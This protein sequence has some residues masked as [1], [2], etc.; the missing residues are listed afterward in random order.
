MAAALRKA[1]AHQAEGAQET[2]QTV[3]GEDWAIAWVPESET[4]LD[5]NEKRIYYRREQP[6]RGRIAPTGATVAATDV[7]HDHIETAIWK[8]GYK[9]EGWL[10]DVIVTPGA[11]ELESTWQR[12]REILH[13]EQVQSACV[14]CKYKMDTVL[15]AI[16]EHMPALLNAGCAVYATVGIETVGPLW[17]GAIDP[18][19]P[20]HGRVSP[21]SIRVNTGKE[22]LYGV[23]AIVVT[24]GPGFL[25]FDTNVTRRLL[26]QL[27][28]ERPL[29]S[30]AAGSPRVVED[31]K[32]I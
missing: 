24:P 6:F 10:W 23:L 4:R 3:L 1:N 20:K 32:R 18:G 8:F 29:T 15:D 2:K 30:L 12:W 19:N 16:T 26:K 27:F 11:P 25:H 13:E 14:D 5:D 9:L 21:V 31:R 17:P 22:W 28:S 7:Q